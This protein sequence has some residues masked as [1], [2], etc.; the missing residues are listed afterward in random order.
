MEQR[1]C[2][3]TKFVF[4]STQ[5]KKYDQITHR[6]GDNLQ[7]QNENITFFFIFTPSFS[8]KKN[9]S[10]IILVTYLFPPFEETFRGPVFPSVWVVIGIKLSP[11]HPLPPSHL[12]PCAFTRG[13]RNVIPI[14]HRDKLGAR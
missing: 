5:P 3:G 2:S 10:R 1:I 9:I 12:P 11:S 6:T 14:P 4:S 8:E 7:L 13:K